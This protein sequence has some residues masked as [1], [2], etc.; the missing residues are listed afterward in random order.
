MAQKKSDLVDVSNAL[1]FRGSSPNF[2]A[3]SLAA[4]N[5]RCTNPRCTQPS[6]HPTLA[7]PNPRCTQPSPHQAEPSR[8][9]MNLECIPSAS[10]LTFPSDPPLTAMSRDYA[11]NPGAAVAGSAT[12]WRRVTATCLPSASRRRLNAAIGMTRRA[13]RVA[14]RREPMLELWGVVRRGRSAT[15]QNSEFRRAGCGVGRAAPR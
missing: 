2:R 12:C 14:E 7:A 8:D 10:A 13:S 11:V 6:L 5:P 3:K 4:P 15:Q 9:V 1:A